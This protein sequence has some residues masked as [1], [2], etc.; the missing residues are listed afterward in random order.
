MLFSICPGLHSPFN[1]PTGLQLLFTQIAVQLISSHAV[2]ILWVT[3]LKYIWFIDRR[4]LDTFANIQGAIIS[5]GKY[6][7]DKKIFSAVILSGLGSRAQQS[8]IGQTMLVIAVLR[9]LSLVR[10]TLSTRSLCAQC[11]VSIILSQECK[12]FQSSVLTMVNSQVSCLGERDGPGPILTGH[13]RWLSRGW[14]EHELARHW[15]IRTDKLHY[16]PDD[17]QEITHRILL[18]HWLQSYLICSDHT[19]HCSVSGGSVDICSKVLT[20]DYNSANRAGSCMRSAYPAWCCGEQ[21][22]IP[23][24]CELELIGNMGDTCHVS[25]T[26]LDTW[27]LSVYTCLL[28]LHVA[29]VACSKQYLPIAGLSCDHK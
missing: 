22:D 14:C 6:F 11:Q 10:G 21:E 26:G 9:I 15:L 2:K 20:E 17:W 28:T 1:F 12:L 7:S 5:K 18:T 8:L 25:L 13:L 23:A 19:Q 27:L 4:L 16:W 24:E 29:I 3:K